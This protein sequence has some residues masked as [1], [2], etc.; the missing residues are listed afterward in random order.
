MPNQFFAPVVAAPLF[1]RNG[2]ADSKLGYRPQRRCPTFCGQKVRQ[3]YRKNGYVFFGINKFTTGQK[4]TSPTLID[5]RGGKNPDSRRG[6]LNVA[7]SRSPGDL[8]SDTAIMSQCQYLI[9]RLRC[10]RRRIA[11]IAR[12][13]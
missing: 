9:N 11:N 3:M 2:F 1:F 6:A 7:I 4:I 5:R 8:T 10:L 12:T 13:V